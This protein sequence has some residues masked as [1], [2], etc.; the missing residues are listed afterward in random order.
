MQV[1]TYG[2]FPLHGTAQYRSLFLGGGGG[3]VHWTWYFFLVP[4]R[5]RFQANSTVTKTWRVNSADHWLAGEN[6]H[7]LR[8]WTCDTGHNRPARFKSAQPVLLTTK[9]MAVSLSVEEVQT[10]LSLIDEE[11]IQRELD[12][13]TQ[14]YIFF[15]ECYDPWHRCFRVFCFVYAC[16]DWFFIKERDWWILKRVTLKERRY[17]HTESSLWCLLLWHEELRIPPPSTDHQ[18]LCGYCLWLFRVVIYSVYPTKILWSVGEVC[19]LFWS[20]FAMCFLV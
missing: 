5:P 15:Q 13:A 3:G 10:F 7:C 12:G 18:R 17:Q 14:K 6:S 2:A 9:K 19:Y 16:R 4:P 1:V 11:Q 20:N 8:H